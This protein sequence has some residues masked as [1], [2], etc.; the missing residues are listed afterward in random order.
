MTE[1]DVADVVVE[2]AVA[3][4]LELTPTDLLSAVGVR[5]LARRA[6]ISPTAIY[7]MFGSLEGLAEA[8]VAMIFDPTRGVSDSGRQG[9]TDIRVSSLPLQTALAFHGRDFDRL[10]GDV[11]L[12]LRMGLWGLGGEATTSAY[13][14]YLRSGATQIVETL[15]P[16]FASWGRD[17]REPF[18]LRQFL[19]VQVSLL[20]GSTIRSIVDPG[21]ID[22]EAYARAAVVTTRVLLRLEGDR[23]T[24]DDRLA[25]S[26]RAS[27]GISVVGPHRAPR[28]AARARVLAAAE[29][30]FVA[31]GLHGAS[32]A[33]V[34]K[35]AQVSASTVY[36]SFADVD[37]VAVQLLLDRAGSLLD[38][39]GPVQDEEAALR[40]IASFVGERLVYAGP[41]VARL[42]GSVPIDDDPI[43]GFVLA[44]MAEPD[45]DAAHAAL[46]LLLS[47]LMQRASKGV[48]PA[49]R[50]ALV[51][52]AP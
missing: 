20:N 4:L 10:R 34:A 1:R 17:V 5:E 6:N 31:H 23:R 37:D 39:E 52:L 28:H 49:V 25:E 50:L 26:D 7:R 24:V 47:R 15:G 18:D 3:A 36:D 30:L 35:A 19:A 14:D 21:S 32:V 46:V 51:V 41:Y 38:A 2:Q 33:Q 40:A 13:G 11:E 43:V 12:R 48:D 22:R 16:L 8:V 45:A 42:A 27:S 29:E 44:S 9:T